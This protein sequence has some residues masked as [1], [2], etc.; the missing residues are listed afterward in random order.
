MRASCGDRCGPRVV[1]LCSA[2]ILLTIFF[3]PVSALDA[4]FYIAENGSMFHAEL[5]I[6]N[7]D[8]YE[9]SEPGM[10]GEKV[11]VEVS[12]I[13]LTGESGTG[14]EFADTWEGIS[15]EKGNYTIGYDQEFGNHD[16]RVIFDEPYNITMYLPG[17]FGVGNPL[18][19]MVS[20]GGAV[21]KTGNSTEISW[22]AK[23]YVEVRFYDD[24][25]E[26]MLLAFGSFWIVLVIIFL[27]PYL[28]SRRKMK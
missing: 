25:Q 27:I 18:L 2:L 10:L 4:D 8:K 7:A 21:N 14:V 11:P 20:N 1:T 12:N 22:K 5:D 19:G 23:R 13:S 17:E 3:N 6:L 26:K 16:F 9:F 24:L 15:F 28:Q